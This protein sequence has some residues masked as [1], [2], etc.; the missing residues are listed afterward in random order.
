MVAG[1]FRQFLIMLG[2]NWEIGR[3]ERDNT[4]AGGRFPRNGKEV[5]WRA[6]TLEPAHGQNWSLSHESGESLGTRCHSGDVSMH[7]RGDLGVTMLHSLKTPPILPSFS[8]TSHVVT[9]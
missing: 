2:K 4:K 9:L 8:S 3:V 1:W 6:S 5:V 7:V